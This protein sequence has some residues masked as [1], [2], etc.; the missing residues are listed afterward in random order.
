M[1]VGTIVYATNSGLGVLAKE[2]YDN[3]IITDVLVQ[4]HPTLKNNFHWYKDSPALSI[5]NDIA[6]NTTPTPR[7]NKDLIEA[8]I[9]KIDILFLFEIEW[10]SD[11]IQLARK[12]GK[13]LVFMPMYECSP[14][15]ILA[16]CYL[17]VSDLDHEYYTQMYKGRNIKRINVPAHSS[18]SWK[19]RTHANIFIHNAGFH[20]SNDRNGTQKI[21][22][23]IPLIKSRDIEIKIRTQD[24]RYEFGNDKRLSIDTS[25]RDFSELWNE[26]DVF[27]FPEKWN[28]LS[29]PIQEAYSSGMM[30]MCGN[31]FPMNAWLPTEPM[32]NVER[33]SRMNIIHNIPFKSAQ[34]NPIDIANKIDEFANKDIEKYSLM[35]LEWH[36][37][38]SWKVMK[39][40]YIK[41]M[42]KVYEK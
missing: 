23:A 20:N 17:T 31:R 24:L 41:I 26:G 28:G 33:Y 21:I 9:D 14:F 5:V 22:D 7:H 3:G 25:N 11:V 38:N 15:P 35:G 34:Y 42:E 12:K 32:I 18:V 27:L 37:Q 13:K 16:D 10:Y 29:L 1:K 8:F 40:K 2:F 39:N 19:K 36:N 6:I 4:T 30:V